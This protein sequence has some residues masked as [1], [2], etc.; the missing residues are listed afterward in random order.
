MATFTQMA[1]FEAPGTA[2]QSTIYTPSRM[3]KIRACS[4]YRG[5]LR[6]D[7]PPPHELMKLGSVD[8]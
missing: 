1:F 7:L 5:L 6:A 8:S 2:H 3:A 4:T